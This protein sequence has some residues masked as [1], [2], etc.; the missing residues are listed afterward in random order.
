MARRK[1]GAAAPD[2]MREWRAVSNRETRSEEKKTKRKTLQTDEM[3]EAVEL[4]A[5]MRPKPS[6]VCITKLP[7]KYIFM[8]ANPNY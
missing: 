6:D 8:S 7:K 3:T 2:Q 4:H 1:G 5:D